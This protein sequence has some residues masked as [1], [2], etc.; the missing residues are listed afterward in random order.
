M[1]KVKTLVVNDFRSSLKS[2]KEFSEFV[3]WCARESKQTKIQ[4]EFNENELDLLSKFCRF[5]DDCLVYSFTKKYV[6]EN[7]DIII[8][9]S[10]T[11]DYDENKMYDYSVRY[12]YNSSTVD[13]NHNK[14]YNAYFNND[15]TIYF[16]KVRNIIK[17]GY[18]L[19]KFKTCYVVLH[20]FDVRL[21]FKFNN[22]SSLIPLDERS[23]TLVEFVN[24]FNTR[25]SK[26]YEEERR[27]HSEKRLKECEEAEKRIKFS[28]CS[29]KMFHLSEEF[30][31]YSEETSWNNEDY[32]WVYD[33]Q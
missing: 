16:E 24:K 30:S 27:R 8:N 3:Y 13:I 25:W 18:T 19:N 5:M 31:E 33:P 22:P 29:E 7:L 17:N 26:Y 15:N 21:H 23:K 2:K 9:I 1:K 12:Y 32:S 14:M 10:I 11:E 4:V 28:Y 20:L 6:F